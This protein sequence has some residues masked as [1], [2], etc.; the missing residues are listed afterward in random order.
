[1]NYSKDESKLRLKFLSVSF[2]I[3]TFEVIYTH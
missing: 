3:S 2:F 1:L